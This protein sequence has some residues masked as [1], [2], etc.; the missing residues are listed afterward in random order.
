[1]PLT[2]K[3]KEFLD[4]IEKFQA[5]KG[6]GPSQMEIAQHFGFSS[7]GT[8]QKYLVRLKEQGVLDQPLHARRGLS[9]KR[10]SASAGVVGALSLPLL[11]RVAAGKPIEVIENSGAQ[12]FVEVPA[13]F[14][15]KGEH[16]VLEVMGNSM[17]ED[18]ILHGDFVIVKKQKSAEQGQMVV[19]L[20]DDA[21]TVKRFYPKK[22]FIELHPANPAYRPILVSPEQSFQ[23]E[24]I[25]AGVIRRMNV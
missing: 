21:A 17:I 2:P 19:A 12:D 7:L 16:F 6:Y 14:V 3:Q 23:I 22:D 15:K 13:S 4:F 11:G 8:V 20:V 9:V 10:P 25:V 24:G 18:G 5:K 1:M